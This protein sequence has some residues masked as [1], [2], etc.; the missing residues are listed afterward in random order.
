MAAHLCRLS[1]GSATGRLSPVLGRARRAS[2]ARRL[3]LAYRLFSELSAPRPSKQVP[4][5]RPPNAHAF[6]RRF[7]PAV[8]DRTDDPTTLPLSG[9]W[10]FPGRLPSDDERGGVVL[11]LP[12]TLRNHGRRG[13]CIRDRAARDRAAV[14]KDHLR[15][16]GEPERAAR[17]LS[18]QS[19]S[20]SRQ[21]R[22]R[23]ERAGA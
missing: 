23:G 1:G 13:G 11:K 3:R 22:L 4:T 10:R 16:G 7:R 17:G 21:R 19:P 6:F 9:F 18:S 20:R 12:H 14:A 2:L 8:G 5:K 15:V